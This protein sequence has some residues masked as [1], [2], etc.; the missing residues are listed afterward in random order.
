MA[1]S[2]TITKLDS[3]LFP[4]D[5]F[6]CL[7]EFK[8]TL[9]VSGNVDLDRENSETLA[10]ASAQIYGQFVVDPASI[11]LPSS[12]AQRQLAGSTLPR[13]GR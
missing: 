9:P 7:I 10:W 4:G 12:T 11:T 8:N 5:T 1:L 6:R 3:V 2:V 13:F